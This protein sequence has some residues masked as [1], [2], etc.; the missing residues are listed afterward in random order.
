MLEHHKLSLL[1]YALNQK[2]IKMLDR[3]EFWMS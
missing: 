2:H 3:K 1:D